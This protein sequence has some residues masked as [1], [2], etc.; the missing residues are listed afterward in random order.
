LCSFFSDLDDSGV[1]LTSDIDVEEAA[2]YVRPMPHI[3][4]RPTVGMKRPKTKPLHSSTSNKCPRLQSEPDCARCH[5]LLAE[6]KEF[7]QSNALLTEQLNLCRLEG[8]NGIQQGEAP[9]PGKVSRAIAENH[10]VRIIFL[11]LSSVI[12]IK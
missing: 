7:K 10:Q 11:I 3:F 4:D 2:T 9:R 1:D 8:A 5:H 6:K 12:C